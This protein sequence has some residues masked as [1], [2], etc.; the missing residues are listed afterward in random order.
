MALLDTMVVFPMD[1]G[2]GEDIAVNNFHF[3]TTNADPNH[4]ATLDAI[5]VALGNCVEAY[6]TIMANDVFPT[7][8][9]WKVY[10]ALTAPPRA[11]VRDVILKAGLA[12]GA[13]SAVHEL[14]ICTSFQGERISGIPQGRRRGRIYIG[15]ITT[16]AIAGSVVNPTA[17]TAINAAMKGLADQGNEPAGWE[18]CVFSRRGAPP[19]AVPTATA[20]TEGWTDNSMDVQRRRGVK[21]TTRNTWTSV[22]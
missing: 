21:A 16:S 9:R 4:G 10:D 5:Q 7:N 22:T 14:A 19:P 20:V 17:I 15:P 12:T 13:S 8:V 3:R 2:S 11:P 6:M 1:T 18:W